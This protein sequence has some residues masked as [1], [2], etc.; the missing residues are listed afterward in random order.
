MYVK[1]PFPYTLA[2]SLLHVTILEIFD[3]TKFHVSLL[4]VN[5]SEIAGERVKLGI[6]SISSTIVPLSEPIPNNSD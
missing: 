4:P 5:I 6:T 1:V 3:L 2:N